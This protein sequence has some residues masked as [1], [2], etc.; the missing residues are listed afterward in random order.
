[1]PDERLQEIANF[2]VS[3]AKFRLSRV[4][5]ITV[6]PADIIAFSE[7]CEVSKEHAELFLRKF[8]GDMKS[9]LTVFIRG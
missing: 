9:A 8:G 5:V 1:M 4:N 7:E 2:S 6:A 3:N